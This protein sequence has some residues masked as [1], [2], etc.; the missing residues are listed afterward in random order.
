MAIIAQQLVV[1]EQELEQGLEQ[2]QFI[3]VI[4]TIISEEQRASLPPLTVFFDGMLTS[5]LSKY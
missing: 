5:N 3:L 2:G 1:F 4:T